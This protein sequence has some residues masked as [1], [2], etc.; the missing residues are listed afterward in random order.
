VD[1]DGDGDMDL[2]VGN[3]RLQPNFLFDNPGTPF[4]RSV[5]QAHNAQG[6]V[7][8]GYSG[9]YGN[10]RGCDFSDYN[11]DGT[12]D[13]VTAEV[14]LPYRLAYSDMTAVWKNDATVSNNFANVQ[15]VAKLG[16][17]AYQA[18]VAWADFNNDG[19]LDFYVSSG[20]RCSNGS[21]Y[22]QNADYSFTDVS[23]ESGLNAEA[24]FGVAWA[25]FDN[26]GDL[27]MAI[28][29]EFGIRLYRNELTSKGNWV[30]LMLKG[31][32]GN[33]FAIG[34]R[35]KV[36]AGGVT[37]TRFVTAGQGAG[38]QQPYALHIGVGSAA[39]IDSVVLRW[40][41]KKLETLKGLAINAIHTITEKTG[42]SAVLETVVAPRRADL[43]QN[44]PNPFSKSRNGSTNIAY[45]L[46]SS[47]D[48]VLDI[49]DLLGARVK[50]LHAGAQSAGMHFTTWDG[51][52]DAG[53]TVPSGTYQYIL[54]S[55]GAVL[56]KQLVVLK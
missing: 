35:A 1:Y 26:D 41:G 15:L 16:Y 10:T 40:P 47:A 17:T 50:R 9:L 38:C 18:D 30:E 52:N 20:E 14:A 33:S 36:Y 6:S 23:Y 37:Y 21:L 48:I 39:Q 19:R 55:A 27:D 3:D 12:P 49:V 46:P 11:N 28:G 2:Y 24:G 54:S 51:R 25:D 42:T 29:S 7:K 13:L 45:N 53:E 22:M 31:K 43:Q 32:T 56:V 4:F 34:T 8:A 5:A 44:Y